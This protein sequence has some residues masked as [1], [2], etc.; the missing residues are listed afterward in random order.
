MLKSKFWQGFF[1]LSPLICMLLL[2]IGYGFVIFSIFSHLP[3]LEGPGGSPPMSLFGGLGVFLLLV[4]LM[5]VVS[6]ASLVYYI[7]HAANNPNLKENNLLLIWILLFIFASG[8]A[9]LIYW[10]IEIL[11]KP[12]TSR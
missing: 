5:V 12:E 4:F 2:M 7:V 6:L 9:Q 3:E 10:I 11:N 1:A 8:I